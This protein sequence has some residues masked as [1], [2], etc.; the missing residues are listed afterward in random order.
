MNTYNYPNM[1]Q[2]P[3]FPRHQIFNM[4]SITGGLDG[5]KHYPLAPNVTMPLW[6]QNE[7]RIFVKST[8]ERGNAT[9]QIL[10]YEIESEEDDS[11]YVTKDDFA[12]YMQEIKEM[13]ANGKQIISENKSA[14]QQPEPDGSQNIPVFQ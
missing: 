8:D 7:Q 9:Y 14:V 13:I 1:Y 10:K 12:K 4:T 3:T 6:D 11:N 2:Q 5:A